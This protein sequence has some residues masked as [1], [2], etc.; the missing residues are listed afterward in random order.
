MA[1][2]DTSFTISE[3][4]KEEYGRSRPASPAT[5]GQRIVVQAIEIGQIYD[6]CRDACKPVAVKRQ[7]VIGIATQRGRST[8]SSSATGVVALATRLNG[9]LGAAVL[10]CGERPPPLLLPARDSLPRP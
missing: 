10:S 3:N 7:G 5:E 9:C 2:V 8:G 4:G 1:S 6:A